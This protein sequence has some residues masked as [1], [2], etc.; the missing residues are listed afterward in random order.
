MTDTYITIGQKPETRIELLMY[1]ILGSISEK[2][3]AFYNEVGVKPGKI[4]NL[5]M[6]CM[7]TT[8]VL[9]NLL[10]GVVRTDISSENRLNVINTC[11]EEVSRISLNLWMALEASR[12]SKDVSH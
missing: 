11:L 5:E 7:I 12:A 8:N 10:Q 2:I 1:E 6:I 9:V 3:G 4:T